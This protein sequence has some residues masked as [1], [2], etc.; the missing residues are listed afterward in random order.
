MSS[1]LSILSKR[2]LHQPRL[3]N[4]HSICRLQLKCQVNYRTAQLTWARTSVQQ[5]RS[6][7]SRSMASYANVL[8]KAPDVNDNHTCSIDMAEARSIFDHAWKKVESHYGLGNMRLPTELLFLMGAPGAGKGTL[9]PSILQM[10]NITN[11][12]IGISSLLTSPDCKRLK[13][14]GLLIS[15]GYVLEL[16]LHA[17]FQIPNANSGILID[18]FP[19]TALQSQIITLLYEKW[20]EIWFKHIS[21]PLARHFPQP[22]IRFCVL[23][24]D[25]T[26]SIE[27]QLIRGRQIR[28]HN[29]TVR[30]TGF[31]TLYEERATDFDEN[32]IRER[33]HIFKTNY[34]SLLQLRSQFPFHLIHAYGSIDQVLA[35]I[36]HQMQKDNVKDLGQPDALSLNDPIKLQH[37][38]QYLQLHVLP[39]LAHQPGLNK[40]HDVSL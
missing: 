30:Q 8:Q 29:D 9:T 13:D 38:I 1:S 26:T 3:S 6:F 7:L 14:Q 32:L 33:Y 15:D 10:R 25:E 36:Q 11:P 5:R 34:D 18:G 17:I 4:A 27:R 39:H 31:G 28:E 22:Q 40:Q 21:T 24:V 19:R 35:K 12:P 23:H 2:A 37:A 16:L 20:T